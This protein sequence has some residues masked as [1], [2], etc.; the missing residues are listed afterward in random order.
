MKLRLIAL[1][2]LMA[3]FSFSASAALTGND[4]LEACNGKGHFE[5]LSDSFG[6][7]ACVSTVTGF[8]EGANYVA[9]L[10]AL[11]QGAK[12]NDDLRSSN[13]VC[14]SDNPGVTMDQIKRM[15]EKRANEHPEVLDKNVGLLIFP[16]LAQAYPC[17]KTTPP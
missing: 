6:E 3:L 11:A 17:K 12:T 7:M 9:A 2:L 8:V 16:V 1:G 14:P 5:G 4:L 10:V 13:I 15:L